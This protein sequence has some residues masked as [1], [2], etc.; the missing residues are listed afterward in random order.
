MHALGSGGL[1]VWVEQ[2]FLKRFPLDALRAADY[3]SVYCVA[4]GTMHFGLGELL[5]EDSLTTYQDPAAHRAHV[6][7]IFCRLQSFN[8]I[9]WAQFIHKKPLEPMTDF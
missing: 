4:D 7:H 3:I 2:I 1:G 6:L 9:R 8:N 5:Q